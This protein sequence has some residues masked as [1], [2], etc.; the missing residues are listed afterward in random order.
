[1]AKCQEKTTSE[2]RT[3]RTHVQFVRYCSYNNLSVTGWAINASKIK[4]HQ[5]LISLTHLQLSISQYK[6]C[7]FKKK[8]APTSTTSSNT[9]PTQPKPVPKVTTTETK[10]PDDKKP[11]EFHNFLKVDRSLRPNGFHCQEQDTK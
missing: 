11:A 9:M 7:D 4:K 5:A 10:K 8:K 6:S 2:A 3:V 1:M